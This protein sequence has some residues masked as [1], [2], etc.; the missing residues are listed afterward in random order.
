MNPTKSYK[1]KSS[2]GGRSSRLFGPLSRH[3]LW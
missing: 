2:S 1:P 3:A